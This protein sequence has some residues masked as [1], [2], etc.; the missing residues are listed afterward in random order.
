[1]QN[2]FKANRFGLKMLFSLPVIA[3]LLTITKFVSLDF[4]VLL[5]I[6]V[7]TWHF[8]LLPILFYFF[9]KVIKP[10][11]LHFLLTKYFFLQQ[12]LAMN[13]L[14]EIRNNMQYLAVKLVNSCYLMFLDPMKSHVIS[15][16]CRYRQ[17]FLIIFVKV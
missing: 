17:Q 8:E 13:P 5:S 10:H 7:S 15:R 3:L 6:S 4:S 2:S 14:N 9:Q 1:M 11:N 16:N 12:S